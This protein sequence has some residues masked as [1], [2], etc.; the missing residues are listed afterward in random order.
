[1]KLG[2][3]RTQNSS[4]IFKWF[5]GDEISFDSSFWCHDASIDDLEKN[6]LEYVS[7]TKC[8]HNYKCEIDNVNAFCQKE[9]MHKKNNAEKVEFKYLFLL[10]IQILILAFV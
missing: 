2:A 8:V 5:D 6:C 9:M 10:F 3:S 4:N 7:P 1:M